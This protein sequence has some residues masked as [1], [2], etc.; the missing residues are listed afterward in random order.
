MSQK[1]SKDAEDVVAVDRTKQRRTIRVDKQQHIES[2]GGS[3]RDVKHVKS[4]DS[5]KVFD[6]DN[7]VIS[8]I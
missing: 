6:S 3:S 8:A 7:T 4:A 1:N 5:A 2:H